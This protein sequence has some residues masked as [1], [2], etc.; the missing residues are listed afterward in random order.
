MINKAISLEFTDSVTRNVSTI[1]F[2]LMFLLMSPALFAEGA[3]ENL[4]I[5]TEPDSAP[6]ISTPQEKNPNL[7]DPQVSRLCGAMGPTFT[8]KNLIKDQIKELTPDKQKPAKI[9]PFAL[10]YYMVASDP[11]LHEFAD[12]VLLR[13]GCTPPVRN[14][15]PVIDASDSLPRDR[16]TSDVSENH[17]QLLKDRYAH[18]LLGDRIARDIPNFLGSPEADHEQKSQK[19]LIGTMNELISASK[20]EA[21]FL[22]HGPECVQ[23]KSL[24]EGLC[25]GKITKKE[26]RDSFVDGVKGKVDPQLG[27]APVAIPITFALAQTT[28]K[29]LNMYHAQHS[30]QLIDKHNDSRLETLTAESEN[31]GQ[32]IEKTQKEADEFYKSQE[33][34]SIEEFDSEKHYEIQKKQHDYEERKREVDEQIASISEESTK[35]FDD[36]LIVEEFEAVAFPELIE[37]TIGLMH[38]CYPE[39]RGEDVD[40]EEIE[41]PNSH[42]SQCDEEAALLDLVKLDNTDQATKD[43]IYA[44]RQ[45]DLIRQKT[46]L[47]QNWPKCLQPQAEDCSDKI[48]TH[49]RNHGYPGGLKE[50]C[51]DNSAAEVCTGTLISEEMKNLLMENLDQLPDEKELNPILQRLG[52]IK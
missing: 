4:T 47:W 44:E 49:L 23:A 38:Q 29:L 33:G 1:L 17:I 27:I 19:F 14:E 11:E 36:E 7:S 40:F 48:E 16:F 3:Q 2:T 52:I 37:Q 34:K 5:P 41:I 8:L 32:A 42:I 28:D 30:Q 35:T 20:S 12:T 25:T 39:T 26:L 13:H 45:L 6:E 22:R 50:F 10:A 51:R 43:A 15:L 18:Y 46:N 31:L 9:D 24:T 21:A